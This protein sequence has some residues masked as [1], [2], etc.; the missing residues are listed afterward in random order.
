[1]KFSK[2]VI[3]FLGTAVFMSACAKNKSHR[4]IARPA[5]GTAGLNNDAQTSKVPGIDDVQTASKTKLETG[6]L[7]GAN[8]RVPQIPAERLAETSTQQIAQSTTPQMQ[9]ASEAEVNG[10]PPND[11]GNHN[12][13]CGTAY[14][15]NN[16]MWYPGL[17]FPPSQVRI[18]T[19]H[20]GGQVSEEEMYKCEAGNGYVYTDARQDGLMALVAQ[21]YRKLPAYLDVPSRRLSR[22]IQDVKVQSNLLKVGSVNVTVA[23]F[24]GK[25]A[26]G[27]N[28]YNHV[29]L[30]GSIKKSGRAKLHAAGNANYEGELTC[31]DVSGTCDNAI[32]RLDHVISRETEVLRPAKTGKNKKNATLK[33]RIRKRAGVGA[34]AFIVIR[35]GDAHVT[36]SEAERRG[37]RSLNNRAHQLFAQIMSNTVNNTCL[38]ILSDLK[39]GRRKIPRCAYQRLQQECAR[40]SYHQPAA[41]EFNLRTWAVVH[42]R[43]GFEFSMMNDS[44]DAKL[45]VRGPLVA[46]NAKPMWSRPLKIKGP[47]AAGIEN[48]FLVANDG[49]GNLNL[50]L[51]FNGQYKAQSRINVTSISHDVRFGASA[52]E[53]SQAQVPEVETS[54]L[55]EQRDV[56]AADNEEQQ[57]EG[58]EEKPAASAAPAVAQP[59]PEPPVTQAPL[60][61][62]ADKAATQEPAAAAPT[63]N[64]GNVPPASEIPAVDDSTQTPT[65]GSFDEEQ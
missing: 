31:A 43:S 19:G 21:N 57:V 37:Y 22:R 26:N 32:L 2:I 54:A 48:A 11:G 60:T 34:I 64:A 61:Q 30:A 24:A 53:V 58:E 20:G 36:M 62:P 9:T 4:R 13:E 63:A 6:T 55:A 25:D 3:L 10:E 8:E 35:N 23:L 41:A 50:Q 56:Q 18:C 52:D 65:A 7:S 1:M 39:E 15:A 59:V 38:N 5:A 14:R 46:T 51:D 49:G 40:S 17:P 29:R 12:A 28:R 44:G 33:K 27:K 47:M 45:S 16:D 42:G